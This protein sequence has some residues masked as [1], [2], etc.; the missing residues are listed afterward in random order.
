MKYLFNKIAFLLNYL[1]NFRTINQFK[2]INNK[3]YKTIEDREV[4]RIILK[5]RIIKMV[6]DYITINTSSEFIPPWYKTNAEIRE[7]VIHK[8]GEEMEQLGIKLY[9]N[10]KLSA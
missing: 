1:R 6:R 3:L 7:E 5:G 8:Y 2:K 9:H 10:L 4:D